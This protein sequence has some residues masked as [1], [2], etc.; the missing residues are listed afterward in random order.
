MS[1]IKDSLEVD[2]QRY[3]MMYIELENSILV[4]FS[5]GNPRLGT[6]AAAT[7]I[8]LSSIILGGRSILLA[9]SLALF[10]FQRFRIPVLLSL[11]VSEGVDEKKILDAFLKLLDRVSRRRAQIA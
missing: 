1:C 8:G 9:K 4:V 11:Y 10:L 6:L 3:T 7:D 2:D 5:E